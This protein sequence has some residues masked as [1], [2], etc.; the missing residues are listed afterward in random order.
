MTRV[1]H[2]AS[3]VAARNQ[4]GQ[5]KAGSGLIGGSTDGCASA[6]LVDDVASTMLHA[7][8][9][10]HANLML[11]VEIEAEAEKLDEKQD[12]DDGPSHSRPGLVGVHDWDS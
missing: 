12:P 3:Q 2:G 7:D 8:Y 1:R 11:Q 5:R 9:V 6:Y 4:L 10:N